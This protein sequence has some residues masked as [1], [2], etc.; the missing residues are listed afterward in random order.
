MSQPDRKEPESVEDVL[1]EIHTATRAADEQWQPDSAIPDTAFEWRDWHDRITA[2]LER[3][4]LKYLSVIV[5]R[6]Y[7]RAAL[8]NVAID[9]ENSGLPWGKWASEKAAEIRR[10]AEGK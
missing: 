10:I 7:E 8:L 3:E 4:R 2:A 9:I 6:T 5:D 1:A